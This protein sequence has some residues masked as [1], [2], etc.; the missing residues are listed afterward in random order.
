MSYLKD[1]KDTIK[2]A[3]GQ[4]VKWRQEAFYNPDM[5]E[6]NMDKVNTFVKLLPPDIKKQ[7]IKAA[8]AK[9]DNETF[10]DYIEEK[11]NKE[12]REEEQIEANE[13]APQ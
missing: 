1:K 7:V 12:V 10:Y 11:F 9:K 3:S 8:N 5:Y 4:I 2:D 6:E 13:E